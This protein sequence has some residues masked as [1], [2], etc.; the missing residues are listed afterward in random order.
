MRR[1]KS[2]ILA[3][4]FLGAPSF[5]EVPDME[6][7]LN[8]D[9][10]EL[11][12]IEITST[13]RAK[14]RLF[15]APISTFRL[16]RQEILASGVTTL[17]ELFRLIPGVFVRE[18]RNGVIDIQMRGLNMLPSNVFNSFPSN[19]TLLM[20]DNR[21]VYNYF[22]GGILLHT[23]PVQINDI[24]SVEV[25]QGA[26]SALYGPNAGTGV[27]HIKTLSS[28]G[29]SA[30]YAR[31][32]GG[33]T[34]DDSSYSG[35]IFA[36]QSYEDDSMFLMLSGHT[37]RRD[38]DDDVY[39][40]A[41]QDSRLDRTELLSTQGISGPA[42]GEPRW[43]D[44]SLSVDSDSIHAFSR[45]NLG[46]DHTL[47]VSGGYHLGNAQVILLDDG[48]VP[49]S[50]YKHEE[51]WLN[52]IYN[53]DKLEIQA[54]MD[55][56]RAV[57]P[58]RDALLDSR[59][60]RANLSAQYEADLDVVKLTPILEW[61]TIERNGGIAGDEAKPS[62]NSQS[63]ALKLDRH[64]E[65]GLRVLAVGRGDHFEFKDSIEYSYIGAATYLLDK[66]NIFRLSYGRSYRTPF[67]V[68]TFTKTDFPPIPRFAEGA[69]YR[70]NSNLDLVEYQTAELGLRSIQADHVSVDFAAF[71]NQTRDYSNFYINPDF[72][73][74]E[75]DGRNP[76]L[77]KTY[78]NSLEAQQFG[79]TVSVAFQ[80][81]T[82]V[83]ANSFLTLQYTELDGGL[84]VNNVGV[85][86]TPAKHIDT[87][88]MFGGT[89]L[90][91]RPTDDLKL[92]AQLYYYSSHG[93]TYSNFANGYKRIGA[94][95]IGNFKASYQVTEN[96]KPYIVVNNLSFTGSKQQVP[97]QD[98]LGLQT[99]IG[100]EVNL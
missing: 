50:P 1:A 44:P 43:P 3:C 33:A 36:N 28:T 93:F 86:D 46:E 47:K 30:T 87:P 64:F 99:L 40:S 73:T 58:P 24:A 80:P 18:I 74:I 57:V 13:T 63:L 20:V 14:E 38:R 2:F 70:G 55:E 88:E 21:V 96:L 79:G 71:F 11:L 98:E 6:Q 29:G 12:E 53:F 65:N 56:H 31:F 10:S 68:E 95:A 32:E 23:I 9:V 27:I 35:A 82:N 94:R 83:R 89:N 76:I 90:L 62:I 78:N 97:T 16:D 60:K 75:L 54:A 4:A 91:Y 41:R 25:V 69:S 48:S 17:P 61:R 7:L 66:D 85:V 15:D 26:V 77:L 37:L 52:V 22:N 39:F 81:F 51:G 84:G 19:A 45:F 42:Y 72:P 5:A 59:F 92:W 67:F 34:S 8:L 49:T 100:L